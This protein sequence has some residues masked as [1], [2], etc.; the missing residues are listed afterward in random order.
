LSQ[1]IRQLE[2]EL[3]IEVF[4]RHP[5]GV[6]LTAAG[7]D[8]LP[9][10]QA[11]VQS[12]DDA[13]AT[14][15]AHARGR[16]RELRVGFLPPLTGFATE[17]LSAYEQDQPLIKVVIQQIGYQDHVHAVRRREVDVALVW[18][19]LE[20]Q[21]IVLDPLLEEPRAVCL[22]VEHPLAERRALR[23]EEV[24]NEPVLRLPDGF[25][26][27][28]SDFMHLTARRRTP[29]RLTEQVP[30][31]MDEG[32]WL[33]ASGRAICVGPLSVAQT[34]VRPG[35]VTIPISDVEPVTIAIAR[36][37]DDRRASV[38][39]FGHVAREHLRSIAAQRIEADA[40]LPALSHPQRSRDRS[41]DAQRAT[42]GGGVAG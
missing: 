11:A 13:I 10:A 42:R 20:G 14:G 17:V 25:P 1:T 16:R 27:D 33:I 30:G 2:R 15:R 24:E 40:A 21:D 28:V 29:V 4:E 31:S 6:S 12:S 19:E 23:F 34:L 41:V 26:S 18:A 38:R 37:N 7:A 8:L 9:H 22:H 3:G 32:I 35:L 39:A 5:R 36:R